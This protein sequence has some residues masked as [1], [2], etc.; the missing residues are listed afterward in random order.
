MMLVKAFIVSYRTAQ[1]EH[2]TYTFTVSFLIYQ[3][4]Y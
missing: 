3:H 2:G 1:Q 4:Q